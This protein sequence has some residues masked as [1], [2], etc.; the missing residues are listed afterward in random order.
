MNKIITF[1]V[2]RITTNKQTKKTKENKTKFISNWLSSVLHT[3][4]KSIAFSSSIYR[5]FSCGIGSV[6]CFIQIKINK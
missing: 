4:I 5:P 1:T 2:F 6:L 3:Q